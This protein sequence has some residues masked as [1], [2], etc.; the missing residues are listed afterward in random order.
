VTQPQSEPRRVEPTGDPAVDALISAMVCP[1][2]RTIYNAAKAQC[3]DP[4][5]HDNRPAIGGTVP[6]DTLSV[7]EHDGCTWPARLSGLTD[8][9][10]QELAERFRVALAAPGRITVLPPTE[11]EREQAAYERGIFDAGV[12]EGLR[13]ATEGWEREWGVDLADGGDIWCSANEPAARQVAA[14][15]ASPRARVVSRLVGPWEPAEQRKAPPGHEGCDLDRS[16]SGGPYACLQA[17]EQTQGGA[18]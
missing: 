8:A 3:T 18:R 9:A 16:C 5:H 4:W 17:A 15:H 10:A 7:A 6:A 12:A 13:Q 14:H 2:C 11:V 1:S